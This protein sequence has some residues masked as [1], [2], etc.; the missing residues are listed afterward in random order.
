[1]LLVLLVLVLVVMVLLLMVL[2]RIVMVRR[3]PRAESLLCA[4]RGS[5]GRSSRSSNSS[6]RATNCCSVR[7]IIMVQRGIRHASMCA[8]V[9]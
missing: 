7:I 4:V 3:R 1:M 9:R 2:L 6:S 8:A 5:S